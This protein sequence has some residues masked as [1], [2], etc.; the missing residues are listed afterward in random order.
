VRRHDEVGQRKQGIDRLPVTLLGRL[1]FEVIK[2]RTGD[3]A[4]PQAAVQGVVADNGPA[5]GVDEERWAPRF[6]SR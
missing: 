5:H 2:S 6:S 3:P 1:F 4:F